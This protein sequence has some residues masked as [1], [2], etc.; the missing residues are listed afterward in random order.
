MCESGRILHH[1]LHGASDPRNTIAIVGF[2][3]EHTT[4]RRIMERRPTIK[5]FDQNV[6]LRADVEVLDGYSAHA[7]RTELQRWLDGTKI[8]APVCL[9][10]G[11]PPAQTALIAQLSAKG[12]SV[13]APAPGDR[14]NLT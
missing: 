1:L 13:T 9:V 7:D 6:A 12:Y 5:I 14:V 10:H 8:K 2:Q 11:E 4:G 3:A